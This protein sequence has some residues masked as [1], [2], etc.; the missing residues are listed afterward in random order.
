[1]KIRKDRMSSLLIAAVLSVMTVRAASAAPLNISDVPLF[2]ATGAEPNIMLMF[3]SSGSMT[4]ILPEPPYDPNTTYLSNCPTNNSNRIAAGANIDLIVSSG[5]PRIEINGSGSHL[6]GTGPTSNGV[7]RRCF[8]SDWSYTARLEYPQGNYLGAVYSGNFLNWYFNP[9]NDPT[10]CATNWTTGGKKPCA[11]TRLMVAKAAGVSLIASM[12]SGIRAAL[13]TYNN[14]HGGALQS[15]M[16]ILDAAKRAA[17]TTAINNMVSSGA[18]PLAE[19]LRDIGF[20]FSMGAG[21]T[22]L[23]LHP[24]TANESEETRADIFATEG[25]T[26]HASWTAAGVTNPIQYRCQK[27]FAVLLTDG[28]PQEDR[29]ISSHLRDY[30]GECAAGACWAGYNTNSLPSGPLANGGFGNG[31]Q[32]G[33]S[34]EPQ[35]SDYL[36][37]VAAAL[38]DMDLRPDLTKTSD[39]EKNNVITYLIGLA[40]P[41]LTNDPLTQAAADRGGGEKFLAGSESEL[42]AAFQSALASI[43]NR[44]GSASSA[45]VNSGSINSDTRLFQAVFDSGDWSGRLFARS[46]ARQGETA[47]VDEGEL[48]TA[49]Y[50]T[51]PSPDSRAII[52]V[53]GSSDADFAGVPFRW[54]DID[55]NRQ[56][57]LRNNGAD[58]VTRGSNRLAWLRGVQ[59]NEAP[60]GEQFRKRTRLLGDIV[61]S[62]P[63]FVGAPAFRY[64]DTLEDEPYSVFR[65]NNQN[66]D[67]MVYVGANDGMMHAFH[68]DDSTPTGAVIERMAFIPKTVFRNLHRLTDPGYSH[69]FYADGSPVTGDAFVG[70]AWRTMLVA[71]LNKGGQ[72]VYALDITD[73]DAFSEANAD[74]IFKWEFT[75]AEDADLGYTY[76][77]P[78]IIRMNDGTWVAA[79]GNGYN[80]TVADGQASAT[81]NAVLYFVNLNTGALIKKID[82]GE[83]TADDPTTADAASQRPNGLSTPVFVDIDGDSDVDLGYAGDL[84]GN[85]WKFDLSSA[86][87]DAW[88]VSYGGE[89][90]FTAINDSGVNQPI[91]SRPNVARGP[92]GVGLMVLFGTG[93]YLETGDT[94]MANLSTS[95]FYGLIDANTGTSSDLIG[96]R[97]SSLTEQTIT[98]EAGGLR[99]TSGNAIASGDK[100]WFLDLQVSTNFQGE[101]QVTDSLIRN[102]HVVFTTLIPNTD[103]CGWGGTSWLM[104]LNLFT[105]A[106]ALTTPF[107][108][109]NNGLFDDTTTVDGVTLPISGVQTTVGITPKPAPLSGEKCDYLIFPGTS[110]G[111]ETRCRDPGLRGFGRQSWRQAH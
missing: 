30:I 107:D 27:S 3:D 79:F 21:G 64:P 40:D 87:P 26:R 57:E 73:P 50:A 81:G 80:N 44:I 43:Q 13:S 102:N 34:Y 48:G 92:G 12:P 104:E 45:S 60:N 76:S 74:D 88:D 29:A 8:V 103:A 93:K 77:R 106:R 96:D 54:D 1:M 65:A 14:L 10:G 41:A 70:G 67:H 86:D 97:D 39:E 63:A 24:G 19:T 110:G 25:A 83:G 7:S 58:T 105:G 82:T 32:Q 71:G 84:F 55:A 33:R 72:G 53:N 109:N 85:L 37:D 31:T 6:W 5:V 23:T 17:L 28:R 66:R 78:S 98:S 22:E 18:T 59:T 69:T 42:V 51:L 46:V 100:G 4:N 99:T 90:L 62:A 89:P 68:T 111:T 11:K 2:L 91:T 95:S 16:G 47:G 35:G 15:Q 20:Y 36:D 49:V 56:N 75:D 52:T 94:T 61:N 38:Y 108:L 101:M 9:A